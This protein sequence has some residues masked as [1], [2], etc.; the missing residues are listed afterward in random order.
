MF[1]AVDKTDLQP[2]EAASRKTPIT[3]TAQPIIPASHA[4]PCGTLYFRK[5]GK[6]IP[7]TAAIAIHDAGV[8]KSHGEAINAEVAA[9]PASTRNVEVHL[10]CHKGQKTKKGATNKSCPLSIAPA[11]T[12]QPHENQRFFK[13]ASAANR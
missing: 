3:N 7:A 6:L 1:G 11:A 2:G 9:N 8:R 13:A 5:T 12:K 4:L 10:F